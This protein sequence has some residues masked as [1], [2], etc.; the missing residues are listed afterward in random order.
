MKSIKNVVYLDHTAKEII[1]EGEI[2]KRQNLGHRL[3][4]CY[5]DEAKK[6]KKYKRA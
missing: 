2:E 6:Y 3:G 5:A 4:W 1:N